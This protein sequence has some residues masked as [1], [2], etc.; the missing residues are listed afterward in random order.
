M[1]IPDQESQGKVSSLKALDIEK[2]LLDRL[3]DTPGK[4]PSERPNERQK[5]SAAQS[6]STYRGMDK[7]QMATIYKGGKQ[8]K[9]F[10]SQM[11]AIVTKRHQKLPSELLAQSPPI[12]E[13]KSISTA[14]FLAENSTDSSKNAS[15]LYR[16][17]STF[18][19]KSSDQYIKNSNESQ[20]SSDQYIKNSNESPP[21]SGNQLP[22]AF[23]DGSK[24]NMTSSAEVCDQILLSPAK[25]SDNEDDSSQQA[26]AIIEIN[27]VSNNPVSK[28]QESDNFNS[29]EKSPLR[30]TNNKT[31][32]LIHDKSSD[33]FSEP[34]IK[35]NTKKGRKP[36]SL[37]VDIHEKQRMNTLN[38]ST[39]TA[40]HSKSTSK[41]SIN[42]LDSS[43]GVQRGTQSPKYSEDGSDDVELTSTPAMRK[44]VDKF[45][46][47]NFPGES[48]NNNP[49]PSPIKLKGILSGL[50]ENHHVDLDGHEKDL[51]H[52]EVLVPIQP[53]KHL[54]I[55]DHHQHNHHEEGPH[56]EGNQSPTAHKNSFNLHFFEHGKHQD[57]HH[58][59][60]SPKSHGTEE[61][62]TKQQ[63]ESSTKKEHSIFEHL[64]HK[65]RIEKEHSM[66]EHLLHKGHIEKEHSMFEHLLHKGHI[67]GDFPRHGSGL[68]MFF[69]HSKQH[70]EA[71]EGAENH[72][73]AT[74]L[75]AESTDSSIIGFFFNRRANSTSNDHSESQL[76]VSKFHSRKSRMD[77]EE[78]K[79]SDEKLTTEDPNHQGNEH[80]H[81]ASWHLP[82][83][84]AGKRNKRELSDLK[85]SGE[86][87]EEGDHVAGES[88]KAAQGEGH[89]TGHLAPNNQGLSAEH[90]WNIPKFHF[91]RKS[92]SILVEKYGKK[93]A[94]LGKGAYATVRVVLHAY[95]WVIFLGTQKRKRFQM[96]CSQRIQKEEKGR[97]GKGI[98]QESYFGIL[99]QFLTAASQCSRVYRSNQG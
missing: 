50:K 88:S 90:S 3:R 55:L 11:G 6:D 95:Y 46:H 84:L 76:N 72:S 25:A 74:S 64:L 67:G 80:H 82:K 5:D 8:S 58:H 78:E 35:A 59:E 85:G 23:N 83:F 57:H 4:G 86:P 24:H 92:E 62:T 33:D 94:Y 20:K 21:G 1:D 61:N 45:L 28:I 97:I 79:I 60:E 96:V 77:N 98:R 37:S 81:P 52:K 2:K 63:K 66:F 16:M 26:A 44:K 17:R 68:D 91:P 71:T 10:G 70:Q 93:D 13:Q 42:L 54:G 22:S 9:S 38:S 41:S 29:S 43:H 75:D 89:D 69:H 31:H 30:P 48:E 15:F 32:A 73:E 18:R 12:E 36:K 53:K 51:I 40:S 7:N 65:G 47:K 56:E 34:E 14:S 39:D 19:K 27:A 49:N 87:E 99:Y